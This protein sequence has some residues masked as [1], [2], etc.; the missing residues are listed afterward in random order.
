MT[1]KAP[2]GSPQYFENIKERAERRFDRIDKLPP[3]TR[4]LIH[5]FGW[6][7]V[8][9]FLDLGERR[10]TVIRDYITRIRAYNA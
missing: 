5:E 6:A 9:I 7:S 8:K 10:P 1:A 3:E 4:A 2:I